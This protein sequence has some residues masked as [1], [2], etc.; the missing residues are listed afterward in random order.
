MG[1]LIYI[2]GSHRWETLPQ[3]HTHETHPQERQL[4]VKAGSLILMYSGLWHRVAE[5]N[6]NQTRLNLFYE[7]GPSWIQASDRYQSNREFL[8]SLTERQKMILRSYDFPNA[9]IK[10][11]AS[12][13]GLFDEVLPNHPKNVPIEIR[14]HLTKLEQNQQSQS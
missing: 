4:K 11:P 8:E 5:N 7:Y 10:T 3:Y 2:P 14:R 9:H 12:S 1:N 13:F 6:S